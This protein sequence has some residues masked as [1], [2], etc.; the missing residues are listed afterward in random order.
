MAQ[1]FLGGDYQ[2]CGTSSLLD[3]DGDGKQLVILHQL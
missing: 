2:S 3:E 1:Q